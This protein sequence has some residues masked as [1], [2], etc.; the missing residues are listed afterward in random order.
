MNCERRMEEVRTH[1]RT[2]A[3]PALLCHNAVTVSNILPYRN[4][5]SR[6]DYWTQIY[7]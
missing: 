3:F 2:F 1:G 6:E 5:I 7:G 4:C